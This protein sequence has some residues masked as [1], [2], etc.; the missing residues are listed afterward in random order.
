MKGKPVKVVAGLFNSD[1][2]G[3]HPLEEKIDMANA[4]SNLEVFLD[5]SYA[6]LGINFRV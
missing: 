2:V 1:V 3:E 4:Y 6:A 5:T